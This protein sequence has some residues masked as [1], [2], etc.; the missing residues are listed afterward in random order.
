MAAECATP[1]LAFGSGKFDRAGI[2]FDKS[3]SSGI[4]GE[5]L[6]CRRNQAEWQGIVVT[7]GKEKALQSAKYKK[8]RTLYAGNRKAR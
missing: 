2:C 8:S 3:E 1:L 7:S 4:A 5:S 6:G